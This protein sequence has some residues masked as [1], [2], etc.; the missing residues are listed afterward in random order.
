MRILL[1]PLI[2]IM[3]T[4][5]TMSQKLAIELSIEWKKTKSHFISTKIEKD[6]TLI[7]FLKIVYRNLSNSDIYFRSIVDDD[8]FPPTTLAALI[9]TEMDL[10]NQ[11]INLPNYSDQKYNIYI[12]PSK[13]FGSCWEV[14]SENINPVKEHM[15]D[16][17]N[18]DLHNIYAALQL[19]QY[20][21]EKGLATQLS[22]IRYHEK[23]EISFNDAR[24]LIPN[25]VPSQ[26]HF[27]DQ[28]LTE[29]KIQ[30]YSEKFIFL[31]KDETHTQELNLIGFYLLGGTYQF[32]FTKK[33]MPTYVLSKSGK[34][35]VLPKHVEKYHLYDEEF[36]T[37]SISIELKR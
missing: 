26:F 34:Q 28:S 15:L 8:V 36:L 25:Q 33:K 6:T 32:S 17:I 7:P 22:C 37:N 30:E 29:N 13:T 12:C 14:L 16:I 35:L 18:N 21:D 23:E 24:K 20:L 10:S 4:S 27:P 3:T 11:L 9:N 5:A 2:S 1:I 31:K 19:Q